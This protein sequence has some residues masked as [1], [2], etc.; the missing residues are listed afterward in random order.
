[1]AAA[2]LDSTVEFAERAKKLKL[3]AE[4]LQVLSDA[5]IDSFGKLC[6][7][8]SSSPHNIDDAIVERWMER[9]FA[10]H[11]L[12]E[13][14]KTTLRK[15]LF[16]SQGLTIQDFKQRLEPPV[17]PIVKKLPAAERISRAQR[18][19]QRITGLVYTPDTTPAHFLTDLF[20]EQLD[21]GVLSWISPDRCASR[22]MEMASQKR[23]KSLQLAQDGSVKLSSKA[24]EVKCEVSSDA[25]LRSAFQRRSLAMDQ[26]GL[27]NFVIVETRIT[28]LFAVM[29][30]EVPE[31][32]QPVSLRQ[33]INADRHLFQLISEDLPTDLSSQPGQKSP[34]DERI[35][36][37]TYSAEVAQFLT[38][39]Q[40][41]DV[42]PAP[43]DKRKPDDSVP[44]P[45]PPFK[46]TRKGEGKGDGKLKPKKVELPPGCVSKN[47]QGKPLCYGYQNGTCRYKGKGKRTRTANFSLNIKARFFEVAYPRLFGLQVFRPLPWIITL[48]RFAI[49]SGCSLQPAYTIFVTFAIQRQAAFP[50][51]GGKQVVGLWHTPEE[52]FRKAL[53]LVHPVDSFKPEDELRKGMAPHLRSQLMQATLEERDAGYLE[54]PYSSSEVDALFGHSRW[55]AIRRFVLVQDEGNKLRPIDDA[56][57][58]Q[59]NAACCTS[60]QLELQDADYVTSQALFVAKRLAETRG[61]RVRGPWRGKCLDLSKAYKQ[62]GVHKE[63]RDLTVILVPN[64]DGSPTY[65]I[66]NSLIFGSADADVSEFLSILGWSH[67]ITGKKGQPFMPKFDVLGMTLDVS[68]LH[69]GTVTLANKECL[70]ATPPRVLSCTATRAPV[71]VWTDGAW[72]ANVATIGAVIYDTSTKEARVMGQQVDEEI[73]RSWTKPSACDLEKEQI[74]SQ[75]ELFAMVS[76][77]ETFK[78]DWVN[79]RVLFFVDNESARFCYQG[80][81]CFSYHA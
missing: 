25:K 40:R 11:P 61:V 79:R 37:Y 76:C 23:D 75:V 35:E 1:M 43:V 24:S 73:V 58:G 45:P 67:A 81:K 52:H 55:N 14:H 28:H 17:D 16:E 78:H 48:L 32:Y 50:Q 29:A 42:S 72:E 33:V 4:A 30:R 38:P 6:F 15:L 68:M 34:L 41:H 44:P 22:S 26:A 49:I 46:K 80:G 21:Q 13:G 36:K 12:D 31:G 20:V 8:V 7:S 9:I 57:E 64:A 3:P 2:T 71:L 5:W 74:I 39:L 54:G 62:V 53:S 59:L 63:H 56:L 77:R 65:F 47:P 19:Q 27:C 51:P 18:Q 10:H 66:S 70:K 60:I 69:Q